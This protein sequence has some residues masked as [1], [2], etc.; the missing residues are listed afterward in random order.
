MKRIA[1]CMMI[2]FF[3]VFLFADVLI[4]KD[5]REI[6]TNYYWKEDRNRIGYFHDGT[7]KYIER[8]L[9]D[10]ETMKNRRVPATAN[11]QP[12]QAPTRS[13]VAVQKVGNPVARINRSKVIVDVKAKLAGKYSGSYHLQKTLLDGHMEAYEYLKRLPATD[14]N[15]QIL[16]NLLK[17]YYPS[18]HLIKTLY[19]GNI[20]A[21]RQLNR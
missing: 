4:L 2:V 3:P 17:K 19:E 15:V 16:G 9:I 5:G 21:Y 1:I 12:Y 7:T 20:K 18:F 8:G 14:V 11:R 10:W 13:P 6:K